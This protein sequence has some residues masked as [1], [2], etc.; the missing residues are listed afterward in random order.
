MFKVLDIQ[1][2]RLHSI[3]KNLVKLAVEN[4]KINAEDYL[5]IIGEKYE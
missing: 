5:K 4:K 3:S 2:N 1:Y